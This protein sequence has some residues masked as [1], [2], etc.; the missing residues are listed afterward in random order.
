MKALRLPTVMPR[1]ASK[2]AT[3]FFGHG[4]ARRVIN[5]SR[6]DN[7]NS[8]PFWTVLGPTYFSQYTINTSWPVTT[9]GVAT[10][11][12]ISWK[13]RPSFDATLSTYSEYHESA[14]NSPWVPLRTAGTRAGER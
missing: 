2:L 3:A 7:P 4:E 10:S 5:L 11:A 14:D 6:F 13:K 12:F 9:A 8:C 1:L